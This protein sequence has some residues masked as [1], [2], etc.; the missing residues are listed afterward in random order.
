MSFEEKLPASSLPTVKRAEAEAGA[1]YLAE[2]LLDV[3]STHPFNLVLTGETAQGD[4]VSVTVEHDHHHGIP[5]NR[6]FR[7]TLMEV[8]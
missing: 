5:K 1:K 2:G 4:R 7:I 6:V 8:R 3:V